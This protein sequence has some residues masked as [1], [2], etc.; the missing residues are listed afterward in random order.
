MNF[1]VD[2]FSGF[3]LLVQPIPQAGE[4]HVMNDDV[5]P[6][7]AAA[8]V[9]ADQPGSVK[10]VDEFGGH[11]RGRGG[12]DQ[13]GDFFRPVAGFLLQLAAGGVIERLLDADESAGQSPAVAEGL[14]AAADEQRVPAARGERRQ[15]AEA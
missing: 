4:R 11:A 12:V 3:L 8:R 10:Q 14:Q 13:L 2:D 5:F 15:R 7:H 9:L 1:E 6:G